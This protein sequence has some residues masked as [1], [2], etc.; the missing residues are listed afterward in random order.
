VNLWFSKHA[1]HNLHRRSGLTFNGV[2]EYFANGA[3]VLGREEKDGT[4]EYYLYSPADKET[5][6]LILAPERR[7]QRI[8]VTFMPIIWRRVAHEFLEQARQAYAE[9]MEGVGA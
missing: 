5:F 1:A 3:A 9:K 2:K 8:V 4:Q 7:G 6:A